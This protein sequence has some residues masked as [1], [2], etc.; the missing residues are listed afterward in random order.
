MCLPSSADMIG[1]TKGNDLSA[2]LA[3]SFSGGLL[4]GFRCGAAR[5]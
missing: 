1:S 2:P 5:W 4:S 3:G